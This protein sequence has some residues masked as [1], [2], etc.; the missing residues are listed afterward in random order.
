MIVF[1]Y[2]T[3]DFKPEEGDF[4]WFFRRYEIDGS[5][6]IYE[7]VYSDRVLTGNGF[8]EIG[9]KKEFQNWRRKYMPEP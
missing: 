2:I 6:K 7:G 1:G 3:E 5:I 8:T 4:T 9:N